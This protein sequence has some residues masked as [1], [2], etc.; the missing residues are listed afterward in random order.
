MRLGSPAVALGSPS[1]RISACR[2]Q[3]GS[4]MPGAR[5][6]LPSAAGL[7]ESAAFALAL[8]HALLLVCWPVR[9]IYAAQSLPDAPCLLS[10]PQSPL[11]R[12]T[13]RGADMASLWE[14]VSL[15]SYPHHR[16]RLIPASGSG[17]RVVIAGASS[18]V[19]RSGSWRKPGQHRP[20]SWRK[21]HRPYTSIRRWTPTAQLARTA[22]ASPCSPG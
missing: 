12:K 7:S 9:T 4:C 19:R 14:P 21:P 11:T 1:R 16:T 15:R 5:L 22:R 13:A 2:T 3:Q 8:H 20:C 17:V 18:H 6:S 10:P